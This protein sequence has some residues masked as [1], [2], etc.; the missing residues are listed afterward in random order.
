MIRKPLVVFLLSMVLVVWHCIHPLR[1]PAMETDSSLSKPALWVERGEDSED[2]KEIIPQEGETGWA[3]DP[4][5]LP[6]GVRQKSEVE[7]S[8]EIRPEE[9]AVKVEG[10][11]VSG[12]L[13]RVVIDD[14]ILSVGDRL[15]SWR[16]MDI[17]EHLVI[18]ETGTERIEIPIN[19]NPLSPN[20]GI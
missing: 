15:E 6:P 18:L 13:K 10:V 4:F 9:K 3:R 1:S 5:S 14:K 7:K 2:F 8:K 16:V 19:E 12:P 11:L 20:S 17:Q